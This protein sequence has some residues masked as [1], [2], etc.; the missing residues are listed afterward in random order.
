MEGKARD[1][2]IFF[3]SLANDYLIAASEAE[4]LEQGGGSDGICVDRLA[5]VPHWQH[6]WDVSLQHR[7][8]L[9]GAAHTAATKV[10]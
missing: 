10:E 7:L 1:A 8:I 3:P 4:V 6:R 5:H 9:S 2:T